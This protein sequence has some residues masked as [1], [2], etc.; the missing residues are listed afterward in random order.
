MWGAEL[1]GVG[2]AGEGVVISGELVSVGDLAVVIDME[3][4]VAAVAGGVGVAGEVEAAAGGE[5]E[6]CAAAVGGGGEEGALLELAAGPD[7]AV[8]LVGAL[9]VVVEDE[10][11]AA[12]VVVGEAGVFEGGVGGVERGPVALEEAGDAE[13]AG[14]GEALQGLG[15]G[16]VAAAGDEGEVADERAAGVVVEEDEDLGVVVVVEGEGDALVVEQALNE[17][18]VGLAVL[19]AGRARGVA[20]G[21]VEAEAAAVG[22]EAVLEDI[23][24]DVGDAG[25]LPQAGVDLVGVE[26]EGGADLEAE[27]AEVVV[28]V[29]GVDAEDEAVDVA[30]GAGAVGE[31]QAAGGAEEGLWREVEVAGEELEGEG[32]GLGQGLVEVDLADD[33][34]GVA[35]ADGE[36]VAGDGV[37]GGQGR[38][39]RPMSSRVSG[40]PRWVRWGTTRRWQRYQPFGTGSPAGVSGG[41]RATEALRRGLLA[42][43]SGGGSSMSATRRRSHCSSR[44]WRAARS[45]HWPMCSRWIFRR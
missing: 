11:A 8:V 34:R 7:V 1:G 33:P 26:G 30:R 27:V 4:H 28:V 42:R 29:E 6:G 12:A 10:A 37:H 2:D 44:R 35:V 31:G 13:G 32:V 25:V 39:R 3:D 15:L 18:E 23:F 36:R 9:V 16:G 17:L 5:G 45:S 40:R 20:G 38:S 14:W 22:G 24:N 19:R 43:T 41:V 21:E